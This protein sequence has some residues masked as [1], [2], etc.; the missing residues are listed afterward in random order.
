MARSDFTSEP[1]K[2]SPKQVYLKS[3]KRADLPNELKQTQRTRQNEETR[4]Y[5]PIERI[6]QKP[7]KNN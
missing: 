3:E 4:E 1:H 5:K 6:R 2:T 7:Q